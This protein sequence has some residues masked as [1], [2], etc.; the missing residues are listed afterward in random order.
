MALAGVGTFPQPGEISPGYNGLLF[1]DELPE[2][3]RTFLEVMRQPLEAQAI[4]ISRAKSTVDYPSS[5]M[6]INLDVVNN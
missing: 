4:I 6:A 3:K 5:I 1:L 2:F